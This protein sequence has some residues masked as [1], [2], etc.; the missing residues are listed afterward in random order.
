MALFF[1]LLLTLS[2]DC[3]VAKEERVKCDVGNATECIEKGC[4][5]DSTNDCYYPLDGKKQK[6]KHLNVDFEDTYP[7]CLFVDCTVDK[8]FVF[9]IRNNLPLVYVDTK[10]LF[11]S[12]HPECKPVIH[13]DEVAIFKFGVEE[14][15]VLSYVSRFNFSPSL[16]CLNCALVSELGKVMLLKL[17]GSKTFTN[18]TLAVPRSS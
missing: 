4:C 11:I 10:K 5:M 12:G 3:S 17:T 9:I 1:V 2:L 7:D 14:C 16:R 6:K 18:R 15:G 13:N 8:K